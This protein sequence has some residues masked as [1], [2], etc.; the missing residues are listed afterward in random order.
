MPPAATNTDACAATDVVVPVIVFVERTLPALARWSTVNESVPL[1]VPFPAVTPAMASFDD[2]ALSEFHAA[3]RAS[4]SAAVLS[5][6]RSVR[7]R[8]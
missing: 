8:A 2:A 1:N 3:G 4:A 5:D 6:D 7:M